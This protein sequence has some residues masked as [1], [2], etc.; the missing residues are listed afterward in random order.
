MTDKH[1]KNLENLDRLIV[2]TKRVLTLDFLGYQSIVKLKSHL[3]CD[4]SVIISGSTCTPHRISDSEVYWTTNCPAGAYFGSH[5]HEWNETIEMVKGY[6]ELKTY[7][8]V[9]VYDVIN[10]KPGDVITIERGIAHD[11]RNVGECDL[12]CKVTHYK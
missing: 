11:F 6:A 12:E 3:K 10:L 4:E 5:F 9:K 7:M 2:K 8:G 1:K